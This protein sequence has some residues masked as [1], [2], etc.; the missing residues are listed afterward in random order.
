MNK[1]YWNDFMQRMEERRL[2]KKSPRLLVK[3]EK[4]SRMTEK[5]MKNLE[6]KTARFMTSDDSHQLTMNWNMSFSTYY[7]HAC[8]FRDSF[9]HH[10]TIFM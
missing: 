8:Y 3:M 9:V 5:V 7:L 2:P 1:K 10:M 6:Q 4:R